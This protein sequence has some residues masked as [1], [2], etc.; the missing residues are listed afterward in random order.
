VVL[1]LSGG[2]SSLQ[3]GS[4]ATGLPLALVLL[5]MC[6]GTLRG[7]LVIHRRGNSSSN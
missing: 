6:A 2:L 4:I 7:L 3:A 5:L 1:L